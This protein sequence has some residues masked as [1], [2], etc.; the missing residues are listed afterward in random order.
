MFFKTFDTN[1][2]WQPNYFVILLYKVTFY[3][4]AVFGKKDY[5]S[6]TC[7]VELL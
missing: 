1:K 3:Q 4:K 6:K 7:S 5:F 2:Y